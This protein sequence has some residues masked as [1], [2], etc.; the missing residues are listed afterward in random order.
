MYWYDNVLL[1]VGLN[2]WALSR[3][4]LTDRIPGMT[5]GHIGFVFNRYYSEVYQG[6]TA[7]F[8]LRALTMV[9]LRFFEIWLLQLLKKAKLDLNDYWKAGHSKVEFD[10]I[11][12]TARSP[13]MSVEESD[14]LAMERGKESEMS[15]Q[16][17]V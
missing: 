3:S 14:S 8:V 15:A 16:T 2:E 13:L 5:K 11:F 12:E 1:H 10:E 4:G 17:A 7:S 9:L 6:I